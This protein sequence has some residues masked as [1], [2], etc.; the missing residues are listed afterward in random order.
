MGEMGR[1]RER[2]REGDRDREGGR[3]REKEREREITIKILVISI[4]G[5]RVTGVFFVSLRCHHI[6][7]CKVYDQATRA[8]LPTSCRM[9]PV[10]DLAISLKN[11]KIFQIPSFRAHT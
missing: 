11:I 2:R 7:N 3:E 9:A 8:P 6:A 4:I 1:G 5:R 10:L